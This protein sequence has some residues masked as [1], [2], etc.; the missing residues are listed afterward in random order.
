MAGAKRLVAVR[1]AKRTPE[2]LVNANWNEPLISFL[3][4]ARV[5][6]AAGG[7]TNGLTGGRPAQVYRSPHRPDPGILTRRKMKSSRPRTRS[8]PTWVMRGLPPFSPSCGGGGP[9]EP[10]RDVRRLEGGHWFSADPGPASEMEAC[11][12]K[13]QNH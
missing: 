11:Q 13:G 10:E 3:V 8:L 12:R 1:T 6:A 7:G 9:C 5:I 2:L 4:P